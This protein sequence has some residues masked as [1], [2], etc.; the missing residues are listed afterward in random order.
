MQAVYASGT[1]AALSQTPG[2]LTFGTTSPSVH[3]VKNVRRLL[4]A[5]AVISLSE[6]TV[7]EP[8]T[9]TLKL[10][11]TSGTPA[12]LAHAISSVTVGLIAASGQNEVD[13]PIELPP[14]IHTV[15]NTAETIELWGSIDA[16]PSTGQITVSEA[17]I[18]V[19]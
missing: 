4:T 3:L 8:I 9:V 13:V 19:E 7:G 6:C 14:C 5:R 10:R 11:R 16:L 1:P 15:G 17:S 18:L 2:L 12:D